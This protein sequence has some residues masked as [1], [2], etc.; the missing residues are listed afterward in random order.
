MT[1]E[2]YKEAKRIIKQYEIE[3]SNIVI[4]KNDKCKLN[5]L[6]ESCCIYPLCDNGCFGCG[7]K[8]E[9]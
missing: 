6:P 2:E 1:K 4:V 9:K 3:Q 8:I 7:H 5:R